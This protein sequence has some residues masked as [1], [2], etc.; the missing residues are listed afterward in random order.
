MLILTRKQGE[1]IIITLDG[2]DIEV[3][4]KGVENN[5][6]RVGVDA[7]RHVSVNRKEIH[8][9]KQGDSHGNK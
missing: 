1:S 3:V 4:I 8:I 9:K 5:K 6:V 7:P 2:H